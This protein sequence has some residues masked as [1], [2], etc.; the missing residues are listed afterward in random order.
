MTY[1]AAGTAGV[2]S[3]VSSGVVGLV[4]RGAGRALGAVVTVLSAVRPAARP[5]HPRGEVLTARLV[6]A[7]LASGEARS[8]ASF[9]DDA[10]ELDVLARFSRSVGLPVPWPDVSGLAVRVPVTPAAGGGGGDVYADLL[11]AGTGRG[12]LGRYLL[13]TT[14]RRRGGFLGTLLPY[15]TP[16]GPVHLGASPLGA[17]TW[18]LSWARPRSGWRP[19]ARLELGDAPGVDLD[20]SFDAVSAA[21]PGLEVYGWHRAVR[22]PGYA[23]ARR[24]RGQHG[25]RGRRGEALV[26]RDSH[27]RPGQT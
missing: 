1:R 27:S 6:V 12:R 26:G 15:G 17:T 21:P 24:A 25:E 20:L 5:V 22:G 23:A 8:G 18:E 16:T 19:F 11:F 4:V 7:G 13:V 2:S 9:L 14:L 3:G 10:A